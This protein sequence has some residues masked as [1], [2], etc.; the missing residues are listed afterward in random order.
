VVDRVSR[1]LQS[2]SAFRAP[3]SHIG[4]DRR[5]TRSSPFSSRNGLLGCTK[6]SPLPWCESPSVSVQRKA[7]LTGLL[8]GRVF[9]LQATCALMN[10][11]VFA[12]YRFLM[13]AQLEHDKAIPSLTQI[14][15]SGAGAGIVSSCVVK[16]PAKGIQGRD[17]LT[18]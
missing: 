1:P 11:V 2:K 15:L 13:K 8:C 17:F 5:G 6:G 16:L 18:L 9:P 7:S 10:G 3:S 4:T 12:S 14:A